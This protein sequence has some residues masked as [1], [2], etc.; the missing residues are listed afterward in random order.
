MQFFSFVWRNIFR[1]K[2]RSALTVVGLAVAVA[3]VVALV[4]ISD[5]FAT[6]FSDLYAQRGID[7]V[8]Q[9]VGGSAELN[10]GLPES[11]RDEIVKLPHVKDTMDGLMDT[12]SIED[13]GL[14]LVIIDGWRAD[15]S[16]FKPM[17]ILSGRALTDNDHH[18]VWVG[19]KLAKIMNVNVGDTI[20]IYQDVPVEVV[21][22]FR[23]QN[24]YEN[25]S[26]KVLLSDMQDYMNRPHEVTGF[27]VKTD[28]P[29]DNTPEH[30][31][32]LAKV[33]EQIE[34]LLHGVAA[35]PTGKF[36]ESV[37]EI[38]LAR[39]VAWVTSAIALFIGAIGMLN[40]MVMSVYERVRE[41]GTLRAIGWRKIRVM[42]MILVEAFVLSFGGALV[43]SVAAILLTRLLSKMPATSGLIGGDIQPVIVV[44]GFVLALLVGLAGAVYPAYWGANLQPI[45]AMR[46]K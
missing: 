18:K 23:S 41:I 1:R 12:I 2:M 17:E 28:I 14:D 36:I 33:G 11:L 6:Q 32:E 42:R 40:T 22:I 30:I 38:K 37:N 16:L 15:S 3:A 35:I 27:I 24:V 45:E 44:Q 10:N 25:G 9:R 29:K 4:G 19:E 8:V 43:G 34:H 31:A 26:L 21:G 20:K 46:R 5:G 13:K 39:A 7:L